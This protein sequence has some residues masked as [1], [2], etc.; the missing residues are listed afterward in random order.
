MH[1]DK[2]N[3]DQYE[4][5]LSLKAYLLNKIEKPE[6][7]KKVQHNKIENVAGSV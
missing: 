3:N 6:S 4:F 1:F 5:Q 7:L 2:G